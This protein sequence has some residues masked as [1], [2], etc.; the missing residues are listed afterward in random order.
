MELFTIRFGRL[1]PVVVLLMVQ[2]PPLEIKLT[3]DISEDDEGG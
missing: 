1:E 3:V 2:T